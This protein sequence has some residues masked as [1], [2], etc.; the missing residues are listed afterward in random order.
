MPVFG[1]LADFLLLLGASPG[2]CSCLLVMWLAGLMLGTVFRF[3]VSGGPSL[4]THC[5]TLS[6]GWGS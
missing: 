4:S 6:L 3:L 5:A 1:G 2:G